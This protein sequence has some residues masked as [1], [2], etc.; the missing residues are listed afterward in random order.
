M[1]SSIRAERYYKWKR[2]Q[3]ANSG[4]FLTWGEK[5][6]ITGNTDFVLSE[7]FSRVIGVK[8]LALS[9]ALTIS[10][11]PLT[12]H[13]DLVTDGDTRIDVKFRL[14]DSDEYPTDNI[15][16]SKIGYGEADQILCVFWDG[17]CRLYDANS[18]RSKGQ[19]SHSAKTAQ[20]SEIIT[21][22]KVSYH[23]DD[24]IWTTT[25]TM[26]DAFQ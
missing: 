13:Y 16:E 14:N 11:A 26:P 25:I 1:D 18:Y 20:E 9:S 15:S 24:A 3:Q 23:P 17:V 6:L 22:G 8:A 2:F 5:H 19:W 7:V 4:S 21:D 12:A 10:Q